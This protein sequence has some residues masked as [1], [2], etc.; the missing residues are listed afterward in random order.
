MRRLIDDLLN[1]SR[2]T[3]RALP[4]RKVSL[5]RI[6]GDVLSDLDELISQHGAMVRCATLPAVAADP[7]QMRQLFQNLLV[8]AIKFH[9]PGIPPVIE[10]ECELVRMELDATLRQTVAA[11]RISIKDNGIGFEEKHADRI[12]QV[13]QRLHGHNE[14]EGSGV[15]L[16]I[17]RKIVERHSGTITA[18]GRSSE[19]A[20]FMVT[21]PLRQPAE[22]V[23]L[24][25]RSEQK[26]D[27]D[28]DG[29]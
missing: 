15:G 20:T 21:L 18:Q 4:F 28:Q 19:G 2:V 1:Y 24:E 27:Y 17:C 26:G 22:A 5:N 14:F 16:A 29:E 23:S 12:F 13:F 25:P 10:I 3:T 8:N 11:C 7:T 9:K 6:C